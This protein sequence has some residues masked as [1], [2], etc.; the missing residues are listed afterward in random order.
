MKWENRR[1]FVCQ[2][3]WRRSNMESVASIRRE[4][5]T[6]LELVKVWRA[7]FC[8]P[9]WHMSFVG[10]VRSRKQG[11]WPRNPNE[12]SRILSRNK[13]IFFVYYEIF[14]MVVSEIK[15]VSNKGFLYFLKV[16]VRKQWGEMELES[17]I[18]KVIKQKLES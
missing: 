14:F 4:Y 1:G 10:E 5:F 16:G 2:E 6:C 18:L 12:E 3:L 7:I 15:R 17:C 9:E 11:V 13:N 8:L